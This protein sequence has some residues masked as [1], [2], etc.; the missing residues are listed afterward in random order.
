V[1]GST[2]RRRVSRTAAAAALALVG[3]LTLAASPAVAE[4]TATAQ[5]RRYVTEWTSW[6]HVRTIAPLIAAA[7]EIGALHVA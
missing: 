5:W 4:P 7:L 3:A 1:N 6:N 2:S